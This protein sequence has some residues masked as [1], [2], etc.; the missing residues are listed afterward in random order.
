MILILMHR[1][2]SKSYLSIQTAF[3]KLGKKYN[4]NFKNH[5]L[6]INRSKK[7]K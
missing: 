2:K 4:L 7:D 6:S 3:I 5:I 1:N